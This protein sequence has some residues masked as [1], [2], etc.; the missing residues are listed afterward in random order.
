[1]YVLHASA[2]E[3]STLTHD[4]SL[5]DSSNLH[6]REC[7]C[8][9]MRC[10]IEGLEIMDLSPFA[11]FSKAIIQHFDCSSDMAAFHF[12]SIDIEMMKPY[13]WAKRVFICLRAPWARVWRPSFAG[14]PRG[15]WSEAKPPW[16][17]EQSELASD[18]DRIES[19]KDG[20]LVGP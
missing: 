7:G 4:R 19:K 10:E 15:N 18:F 9:H 2:G 20:L 8:T 5:V 1:M 11:S 6:D 3:Y 16:G 14:R 12:K 13:V 17:V